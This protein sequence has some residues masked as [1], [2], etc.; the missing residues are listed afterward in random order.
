MNRLVIKFM[1]EYLQLNLNLLCREFTLP[2]L[3]VIYTKLNLPLALTTTAT[4][5]MAT[6]TN[7]RRITRSVGF[8]SNPPK[9]MQSSHK[10]Q[11]I[12]VV[13]E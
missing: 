5:T 4:T 9:N 12:F 10:H 1:L 8:C 7:Y 11:N 3:T 13:M 2:G 6:T